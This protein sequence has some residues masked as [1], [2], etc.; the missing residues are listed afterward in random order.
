MTEHG[1]KPRSW[2]RPL[3][4]WKP[5]ELPGYAEA[6]AKVERGEPLF[7]RRAKGPARPRRTLESLRAEHDELVA[8]RARLGIVRD[9]PAAARLSRR[10]AMRQAARLDRELAKHVALTER[11]DTLAF[12]IRKGEAA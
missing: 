9:D 4:E 7:P 1:P 3:P 11:I 5:T 10:D 12:K 2:V 6:K 8:K